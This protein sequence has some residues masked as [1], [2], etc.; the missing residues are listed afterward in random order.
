MVRRCNRATRFERLA[1]QH[2]KVFPHPHMVRIGRG[3]APQLA[4][5]L[6]PVKLPYT[7]D[8]TIYLGIKQSWFELQRAIIGLQRLCRPV[9][10]VERTGIFGPQWRFARSC[11]Q[12]L[13]EQARRASRIALQPCQSRRKVEH[14]LLAWQSLPELRQQGTGISQPTLL[15]RQLSRLKRP[16]RGG[17]IHQFIRLT[18]RHPFLPTIDSL[19]VPSA[20]RPIVTCSPGW[21][22]PRRSEPPDLASHT[23]PLSS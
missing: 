22:K 17:N 12:S 9:R 15:Q 14:R 8:R 7:Q 16:L 23:L 20:P 4:E 18:V 2:G 1:L 13:F 11:A 21:K 3:N 6:D 5:R 19:N 10:I